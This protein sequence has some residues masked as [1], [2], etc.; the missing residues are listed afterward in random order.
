MGGE[1]DVKGID[2]EKNTNEIPLDWTTTKSKRNV[3]LGEM[4]SIVVT[5][6]GFAVK[7]EQ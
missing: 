5:F 6:S 7:Y 4:A 3:M 2:K 1:R